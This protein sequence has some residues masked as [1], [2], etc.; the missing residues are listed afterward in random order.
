M[1]KDHDYDNIFLNLCNVR[2]NEA[3]EECM[4]SK[5]AIILSEDDVEKPST[6]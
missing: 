3:G 6:S 5:D 1:P 2:C 4:D